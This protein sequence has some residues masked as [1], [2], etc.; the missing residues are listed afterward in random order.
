MSLRYTDLSNTKLYLIQG[1]YLCGSK[2][3]MGTCITT[4][5]LGIGVTN[6]RKHKLEFSYHQVV[7]VITR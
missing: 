7:T 1:T 4:F 2:M 6:M 3:G 5:S